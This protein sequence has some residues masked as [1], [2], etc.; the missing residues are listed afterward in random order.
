MRIDWDE[1]NWPKCGKHGVSKAEIEAVFGNEPA[2]VEDPE[3]SQDEERFKAVGVTQEG[4]HVFVVFTFRQKADE[5]HYRP[6]SARYMHEDEVQY[7]EED[8]R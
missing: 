3:H 7:Y 6:I 5:A 8:P 4:R 1:G 2:I